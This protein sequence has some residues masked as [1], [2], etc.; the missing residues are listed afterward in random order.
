[1]TDLFLITCAASVAFFLLFLLKSSTAKVRRPNRKGEFHPVVHK[2]E[3]AQDPTGDATSGRRF[4][5]YLEE[6][7][8]DFLAAH[9]HQ[10]QTAEALVAG[11]L[12]IPLR[13]H[14]QRSAAPSISS[15]S[16]GRAATP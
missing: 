7:M 11:T 16:P 4:C 13:I 10:N 1:M 9:G 2:L 12:S 14:G 3:Q 5:I 6:Q 8:A 15:S